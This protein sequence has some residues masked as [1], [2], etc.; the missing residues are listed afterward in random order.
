ME[1]SAINHPL[2]IIRIFLP[3]KHKHNLDFMNTTAVYPYLAFNGNCREAM[4][5]YKDCLS[6]ELNMMDFAGSGMES[7]ENK[8][9][10]MHATLMRDGILIMA[11]D[12]DAQH[13]VTFGNSVS[14]SI[15]CDS[16][17]QADEFFNKLAVG[18]QIT[19]PLQDTF[20]GAYFGM[21]TDKFGIHWMFNYDAPKE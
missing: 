9:M 4:T 1:R 18:G 20:W 21:L 11:S 8:D 13:P 7:P 2:V 14:L 16:K 12:G 10:V 6:G 19:M 17:A 3:E 15:N 5:F